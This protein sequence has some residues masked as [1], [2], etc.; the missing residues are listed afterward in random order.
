[1]V[2]GTHS[3]VGKTTA[4]FV[5][6]SLLK[7][8]RY[9]VQPFKQGPDFIDP[10]Y[11]Q[12]VTGKNSINLDFW[13]MRRK[14]IIN[15]FHEAMQDA[16][17]GVVEGMG[18]IFDGHNGT[19][20]GCGADL[21]SLLSISMVLVVDVSGM[22]R[23]VNA[24]LQGFIDYLPSLSIVGILF[25]RVGSKKHYEM[26]L[27]TL[28]PR[29][30]SLSIGYLLNFHSAN[31]PERHLGL[32]TIE[33]NQQMQE[34]MKP[35]L[36]LARST[37]A[38]DSLLQK[39]LPLKNAI[40]KRKASS[41]KKN[42]IRIGIARD[43]AFC[44]YYQKNLEILERSG[45]ALVDFSPINDTTLPDDI[46][47][48][49]LGGGY[50]EIFAKELEEN[51]TLKSQ[52]V[53]RADAGMPIYA[54]CGGFIFLCKTLMLDDSTSYLMAGVFP[55]TIRWDKTFLAI[56]YVRV[57][58]TRGTILGPKNTFVQGQEFHQTRVEKPTAEYCGSYEVTSST[59]EHFFEGYCTKNVLGGYIHLYFPSNPKIVENFIKKGA[60]YR[61]RRHALS[62]S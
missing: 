41:V 9:T 16:E 58:T 43:K 14:E 35:Y 11:H 7:E 33:E 38:L 52:I 17:I 45:A 32:L 51:Q 4:S 15:S 49:Y 28:S 53:K 22:T 13:M 59:Q 25:N 8:K 50:P 37:L 39:I 29:F 21:A 2:C 47:A 30:R 12:F 5:I 40:I 3:G 24:L 55:Y 23:S 6:L 10:G 31:I 61:R 60:L 57:R 62:F 19:Y 20:E 34:I 44:F 48:L 18:A 54:E 46:D 36:E 1:M 26:I 42:H 27:D 56:K